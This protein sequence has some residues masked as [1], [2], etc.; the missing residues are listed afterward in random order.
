MKIELSP[1][2]G[3]YLVVMP[4]VALSLFLGGHSYP[5]LPRVTLCLAFG[6]ALILLVAR[7][8]RRQLS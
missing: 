2:I 7:Y 3:R 8:Q 1:R 5:V 4:T 6:A